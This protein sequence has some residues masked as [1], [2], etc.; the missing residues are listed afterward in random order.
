VPET[1]ARAMAA[2][3]PPLPAGVGGPRLTPQTY[4]RVADDLRRTLQVAQVVCL[5]T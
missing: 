4:H 1:V 5:R 2:T 3:A